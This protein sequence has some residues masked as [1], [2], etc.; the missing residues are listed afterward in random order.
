MSP[1]YKTNFQESHPNGSSLHQ[2]T[3]PLESPLVL[4]PHH[5]AEWVETQYFG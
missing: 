5:L 4:A 3:H 2:A 1:A